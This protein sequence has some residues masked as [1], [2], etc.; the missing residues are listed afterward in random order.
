MGTEKQRVDSGIHIALLY[1]Y[2]K[3]HS[4]EECRVNVKSLLKQAESRGR[5][6]FEELERFVAACIPASCEECSWVRE[7]NRSPCTSLKEAPCRIYLYRV[8][9]H[10][11][12]KGLI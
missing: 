5:M 4:H 3:I 8:L 1:D 9:N 6:S 11:E 2:K 10:L 12:N 7:G